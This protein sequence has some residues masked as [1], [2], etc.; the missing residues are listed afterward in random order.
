MEVYSIKSQGNDRNYEATSPSFIIQ[1]QDRTNPP[2][3][4]NSEKKI[5]TA[6][7]VKIPTVKNNTSIPDYPRMTEIAHKVREKLQ[8]IKVNIQFE[9]DK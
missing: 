4:P 1:K 9:V 7:K 2:T 5:T 6:N 3:E 8:S